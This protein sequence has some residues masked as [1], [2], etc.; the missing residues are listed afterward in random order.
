[1]TTAA[2]GGVHD[3]ALDRGG[4]H[5]SLRAVAI[6]LA[7]AGLTLVIPFVQ[8]VQVYTLAFLLGGCLIVP[9]WFD[10]NRGRL[11]VFAPL[12][13]YGAVY[14]INFGVGA[15]LTV[16]DPALVAY[17]VHVVPFVPRA[18]LYCLL[19]YLALLAGYYLP[20]TRHRPVSRPAEWPRGA[21]LL[22]FVGLIGLVGYLALVA[23]T[24]ASW[25]EGSLPPGLGSLSQ[26]APFFLF[27][28]ALGWLVYFSGRSGRSQR[29]VLFCVLLPAVILIAYLTISVKSLLVALVAVPIIARWYAQARAPWLPIAIFSLVLVFVVFPFYNTYRS[30]YRTDSHADRI[31]QAYENVLHSSSETYQLLSVGTFKRRLALINSVAVVVRDV[32]RWVP[33]ANGETLFAPLAT[34]LVPRFVWPDKPQVELG[35]EFGRRFRL[36][37]YA[38]RKTHVAPSVPGELYWN[39]DLPGII[40]GMALMGLTL[41]WIYRRYGAEGALDPV[42]NAV[43]VV[44]LL[45]ISQLE[46]NLAAVVVGMGRWLVL[47]EALRWIGRRYRL[48]EAGAAS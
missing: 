24:Q 38:S 30:Y 1:M 40:V 44:V 36:T 17:D 26:L 31:E 9:A 21:A 25:V 15:I 10:W 22:L 48:T 32:G 11:D 4:R 37:T 33:H 5:R 7:G 16:E 29:L 45:T 42:P 2:S 39:F 12:H 13:V 3:L 47:I 6:C 46:G 23:W 20:W 34:Y 19:G 8:H 27:A 18:L 14:F 41:R 28:W 43:Y 35:R